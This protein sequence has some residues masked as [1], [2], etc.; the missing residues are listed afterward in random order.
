MI[1]AFALLLIVAGAALAGLD[2]ARHEQ[3]WAAEVWAAL[4]AAVPRLSELPLPLGSIGAALFVVATLAG[5][6]RSRR[7]SAAID[8]P[9]DAADREFLPAALELIDTPPSPVRIAALWFI[10]LGVASAL[11]LSWYGRIDIHA[12]ARGRIQPPGRSKTVQP[13]E[14][15]IVASVAVANGQSVAAGD[16]LLVLDPTESSADSQALA[17]DLESARGE[18]A[19]RKV[20]V[21]QAQAGT[22]DVAAI[23][24]APDVGET[25]RRREQLVLASDLAQLR[26]TLANLAA[27]ADEKHAAR[28]RLAASIAARE[29]LLKLTRERVDMRETI[30]EKGAL[31][32]A[33]VIDSLQ[34][35]QIQE[36]AQ[37]ADKGQ[38]NE[39]EAAIRTIESKAAETISQFIADQSQKLAEAERKA[40]RTA[41]DLVKARSK[42]ERTSIRA[43]IFGT[44]QQL[45]VTTLGQVVTSA[46]ALMTIVP[47]DA[48]VEIEAYVENQDIGFVEAGQSVVVKVDSFPFTRFGTLSGRIER[49]SR[50]AVEQGDANQQADPAAAVRAQPASASP[51]A[52]GRTQNLVF[53]ATIS[54]ERRAIAIDGKDIP[55][56]PGMAVTVEI[57][58]GSRRAIDYVLSPL[59]EIAS[60]AA[61]ER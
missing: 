23:D 49:V 8:A 31:S 60:N 57:L 28:E 10:C 19:R 16:V 6:L 29:S 40:D 21:A 2:L 50:D 47:A 35:H 38:L 37:V 39:T 9:R 56:Q 43:P 34:Q 54:L 18:A 3:P 1:R 36:I 13:F 12:V 4:A 52:Q 27:Q 46:Q 30:N 51:Q 42:N 14:P 24:F 5:H 32:R 20:A 58:T 48:P 55:L 61:H 45:A 59:R 17:R 53:P 25:V 7:K 41:Q 26:S 44:V 22:I 33:L 11:A 15:G